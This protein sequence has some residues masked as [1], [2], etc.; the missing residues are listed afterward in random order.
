MVNYP[1]IG[2]WISRLMGRRWVFLLSVHL[3]YFTL[4][5]MTKMLDAAGFNVVKVKKHW[6]SLEL[7]YIL[8][9]MKTYIPVLP[10]LMRKLFAVLK[11]KQVEVPYWMGQTLVLAQRN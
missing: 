2:A 11:M 10:D 8:F 4:P 3:Y 7:D 9:R 6:Q 1:D 5:T